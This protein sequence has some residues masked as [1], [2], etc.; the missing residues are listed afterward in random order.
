MQVTGIIEAV[1]QKEGRYG[2]K[3][4]ADWYNGFGTA[5]FSKGDKVTLQYETKNGFKD[6]T[7]GE[8]EQKTEEQAIPTK[9]DNKTATMYTSYA[10]DIFATIIQTQGS[11]ILTE[12]W[13]E[14]AKKTM[15]VC[16]DI[17]KQAREAFE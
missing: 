15:Q 10:K 16:I 5:E 13:P 1:S 14:R 3:I 9:S 7:K 11:Q 4:G 6:I 12:D 2:Y 8:A 17:V